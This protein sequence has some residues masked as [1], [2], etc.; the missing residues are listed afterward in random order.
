MS[1]ALAIA[2]PQ[3]GALS[4]TFIRRHMEDLLPGQTIVIARESKG[5]YLGNWDVQAPS[6]VLHRLHR[7]IFSYPNYGLRQALQYYTPWQPDLDISRALD[8]VLQ[9]NNV[10]TIMGEYLNYS[11]EFFLAAKR[12]GI[13]Y[14]AHA[15]GVDVSACLRQPEWVEKY[16]DYAAA[17]GIITMSQFSRKKLIK[18]GLDSSKIHV[19][20]YG[21]DVASTFPQ[22]TPQT[23][24]KCLAVGRFV[25]KKAPL[26]LL[27]AFRQAHRMYPSLHLDYVGDG[28]LLNQAK[29][30]V[31][32]ADLNSAVT[33][34]GGQPAAVVKQHMAAANIFIQHSVTNPETGDE[35]GLPVSILEAMGAGLPVIST[36]HA[37]I[38][39][40]VL[41][42][43]T[44]ILVEE[45]NDAAMGQAIAQ[46]AADPSL[47]E[48]MG[49]ASWQRASDNFTWERERQQ[50]LQVMGLGDYIEI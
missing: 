40:A 13:P 17:A 29:R 48:N 41:H 10:R 43:T 24:V 6:V 20:P 31:Q 28:L 50:L 33:F 3:I 35:E 38:P 15:H 26:T 25:A 36:W 23:I 45:G 4:E 1:Y 30:F 47:R 7:R 19:V 16:A 44:G 32:D 34:H 49:Q 11:F 18:L 8:R 9:K 42:Q 14:Y 46:L 39:E 21:I 22:R 27:A 37:G 12:M 2:A 5:S